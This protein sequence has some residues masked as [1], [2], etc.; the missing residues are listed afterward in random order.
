MLWG[1]SCF[2]SSVYKFFI[3]LSCSVQLN[4]FYLNYCDLLVV[5]IMLNVLIKRKRCFEVANVITVAVVNKI[6]AE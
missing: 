1:T 5:S 6:S 2:K 4:E 3:F